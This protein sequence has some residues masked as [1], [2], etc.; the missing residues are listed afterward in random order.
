MRFKKS[1]TGESDHSCATSQL[2][3]SCVD[4]ILTALGG[5]RKTTCRLRRRRVVSYSRRKVISFI[6][7]SIGMRSDIQFHHTLQPEVCV[8]QG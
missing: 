2:S 8:E 1:S 3:L 5:V 4:S 7:S 6:C